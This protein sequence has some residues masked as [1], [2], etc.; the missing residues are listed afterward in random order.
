VASVPASV[1]IPAGASFANIT[2]R[3]TR[4]R[5]NTPVTI[6]ASANGRSVSAT[7]TVKRR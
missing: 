6:T 2:I 3:T 1:V 5:V 7:L 4:V